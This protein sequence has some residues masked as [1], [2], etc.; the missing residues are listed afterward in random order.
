LREAKTHSSRRGIPV[1]VWNHKLYSIAMSNP[2][3]YFAS[4]L[5]DAHQGKFCQR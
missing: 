3:A 1:F 2:G 5:C 4:R